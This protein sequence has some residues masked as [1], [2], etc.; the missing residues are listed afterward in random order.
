ELQPKSPMVKIGGDESTSQDHKS[1]EVELDTIRFPLKNKRRS[2]QDLNEYNQGGPRP[3][4]D[5]PSKNVHAVLN[6]VS[7]EDEGHTKIVAIDDNDPRKTWRR[8][9]DKK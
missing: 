2:F 3:V 7:K 9:K 6:T 1:K 4:K 5:D 8:Y